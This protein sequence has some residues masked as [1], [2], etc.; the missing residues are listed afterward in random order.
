MRLLI[1]TLC[2]QLIGSLAYCQLNFSGRKSITYS[3]KT[4][5]VFSPG[6]LFFSKQE[7]LVNVD[8]TY[9]QIIYRGS[10]K[11]VS[12][13]SAS[14]KEVLESGMWYVKFDTLFLLCSDSPRIEKFLIN[15]RRVRYF[16]ENENFLRQGGMKSRPLI[17]KRRVNG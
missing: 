12:S 2:A 15:K 17:W 9:S 1:L 10:K 6:G 13:L 14:G 4:V 16:P 7:L 3:P 11:E 8:S 5:K